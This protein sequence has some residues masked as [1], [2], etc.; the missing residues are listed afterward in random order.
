MVVLYERPL[1]QSYHQV[2][3]YSGGICN[4]LSQG[5]AGN[6]PVSGLTFH[7]FFHRQCSL[8]WTKP[9]RV[10]PVLSLLI[11]CLLSRTQISSPSCHKEWWLKRGP[12]RNWWTRRGP[13][14]SW[15]SLE[16][17]SVD[18]DWRPLHTDNDVP[19]TGGLRVV[20]ALQRIINALQTEVSTGIQTNLEWLSV[21][22]SVWNVYVG[23]R[24][25]RVTVSS[26]PRASSCLSI[27]QCYSR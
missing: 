4:S 23:R 19:S 15:S 11:A 1:F 16:P 20:I 13:T 18:P 6:N 22:I 14:T 5:W 9:E 17:P 7:L 21:I 24:E 12:I 8:L 3:N 26:S 25:P 10:G 27:T 2:H